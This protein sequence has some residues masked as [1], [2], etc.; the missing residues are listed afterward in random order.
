M[1]R[2]T[3]VLMVSGRRCTER[4]TGIAGCGLHPDPLEGAIAQDLAVA[5]AIERDATSK[6]KVLD[7]VRFGQVAR[8]PQ[9]DLLGHLLH[10][11][12]Q[13]HVALR[14]PGPG[15]ARRTTEQA[16]E[17]GRRHGEAR[18]IAEVALVQ[19]EGAVFPE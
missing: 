15:G 18:R 11:G 12:R 6:T 4:S 16:V 7:A 1:T 8:E 13:I 2:A 17:L 3:E 9:H 10:R 14:E 5:D 19:P